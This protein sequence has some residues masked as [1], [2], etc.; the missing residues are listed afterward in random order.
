MQSLELKLYTIFTK[1]TAIFTRKAL[2]STD[3]FIEDLTQVPKI[4]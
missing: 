3:K 4:L 1:K 2:T